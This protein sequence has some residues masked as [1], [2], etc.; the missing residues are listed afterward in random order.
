MQIHFFKYQ[1]TGNDFIIMDNRNQ[2][3]EAVLTTEQIAFLCDRRF[4]IGADGLMLLSD[5]KEQDF[6]MIYYNADGRESS[7]CGN[8]GRCI[9]AFAQKIELIDNSCTFEAIDGLHEASIEGNQVKLKMGK[10]HGFR[11]IADDV[12]WLDTGSPHYVQFQE[13]AV[14]KLDVN[15]AGSEIRYSE[16]FRK[17]GT[18][19]NF[20]NI[21]GKALLQVRTYERGVEAETLSCGTGVTACAY[22]YLRAHPANAQTIQVRTEGGALAVE[23]TDFQQANESVFLIGPATF[24]FE[25][26]LSLPNSQ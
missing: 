7:M 14:G 6:R 8:G 15:Q 12:V 24:V 25:G 3:W 4:G 20:V 10:P 17:E 16:P 22:A 19:V 23:I 13:T 21:L 9:V 11:A 1:G 26:I 2:D 5:S 18:N